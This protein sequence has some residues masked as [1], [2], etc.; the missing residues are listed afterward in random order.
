MVSSRGFISMLRGV[1]KTLFVDALRLGFL[2]DRE[3]LAR[4]SLSCARARE[5]V[6]EFAIVDAKKNTGVEEA[7]YPR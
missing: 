6:S 4:G 2:R 5:P 3:V 7:E 1:K